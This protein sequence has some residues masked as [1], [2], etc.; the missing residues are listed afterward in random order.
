MRLGLYGG[1]FDPVHFGHLLLAE[2]CR[3]QLELD[4]IWLIPAGAPPHKQGE[5][6][7]DGNARAEMLEL[8]TAGMPEFH[9]Q[10]FELHREGPSYTVDTLQRLHDEDDSRDLFF[11]M[12]ADSL[13]ELETWREPD[14]ITD[15]ATVVAVNRGDD[16]LP[17]QQSLEMKLGDKIA[18]RIAYAQMPGVDYSSTDIRAR[19]AKGKSVRFQIPRAVEEYIRQHNMYQD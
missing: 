11:L 14:H 16:P 1:T 10:R 13:E 6:I 15:L 5:T 18:R 2:Q 7:T 12:G 8:A 3:E 17:D 9:V 4:E 19:I